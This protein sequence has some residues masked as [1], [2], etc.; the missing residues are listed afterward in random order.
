MALT[1]RLGMWQSDRAL[2]KEN[3]HNLQQAQAALPP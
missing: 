3:L 2:H 1:A